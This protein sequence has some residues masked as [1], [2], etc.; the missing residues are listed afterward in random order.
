MGDADGNAPVKRTMPRIVHRWAMS[1]MGRDASMRRSVWLIWAFCAA[2]CASRSLLM[3]CS[4]DSPGMREP[5][6]C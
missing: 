1:K 4:G 5:P 6:P 3:R 2:R